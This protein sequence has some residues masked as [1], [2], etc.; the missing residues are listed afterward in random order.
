[1]IVAEGELIE[2]H[3]CGFV[4]DADDAVR[5]R[6]CHEHICPKCFACGCQ[7]LRRG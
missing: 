2:C 4:F 5:C 7:P 1:M 3:E 6:E